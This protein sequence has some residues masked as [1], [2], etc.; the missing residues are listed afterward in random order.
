MGM[1]TLRYC[2]VLVAAALTVLPVD[3][4]DRVSDTGRKSADNVENA[5][6]T[7]RKKAKA[8]LLKENIS[9]RSEIDSL[10][11]ELARIR[12]EI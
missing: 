4:E 1:K 5:A 7:P 6:R 12:Q 2:T 9:L 11:A 10:K 8:E 3:G